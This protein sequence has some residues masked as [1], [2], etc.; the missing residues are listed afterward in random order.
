MT[1]GIELALVV[2]AVLVAVLAAFLVIV[3]YNDIIGLQRRCQRAWA[4]IDVALKQRHD[5]LPALV[6]AV[7]SAMSFE[8]SVLEEVTSARARYVP[9]APIH[10]QAIVSEATSTAWGG[11]DRSYFEVVVPS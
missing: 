8:A 2:V 11:R 9:D 3:T 10:E 5:Q 1:I 7:R 6:A 4:N